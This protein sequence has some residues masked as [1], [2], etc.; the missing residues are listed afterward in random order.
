MRAKLIVHDYT[1]IGQAPGPTSLLWT[2]S[3]ENWQ[4]EVNTIVSLS[5]VLTTVDDQLVIQQNGGT[6]TILVNPKAGDIGTNS[7]HE[8]RSLDWNGRLVENYDSETMGMRYML[9]LAY[10]EDSDSDGL[11]NSLEIEEGF[12]PNNEDSD[13]DGISDLEEYQQAE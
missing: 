2:D 6:K 4:Y 9:N 3:I 8:N 11:A 13:D 7:I 12:N 1:L 10:V 5:G